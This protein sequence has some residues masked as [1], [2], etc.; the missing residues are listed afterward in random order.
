VSGPL[1][2]RGAVVTGGGRGI[3]AAIAAALAA[4]GAA[5]IVTARTASE[6][7][8]VAGDLT[9]RGFKAW[10]VACDVTDEEAVRALGDAARARLG[11]VDILVNN[12]G[13]SSSAPFARL[14]LAEWNRVLSVNA[15]GA[16]LAAREFV[17]AMVACGFGRVVSVASV[18]GLEG[19]KYIAHYCAAK[20]ALIG[21]TRALA[22][23]LA[24]TGVT[25]NAVCPGYADT[26]MTEATLATVQSKTGL[27]R[28]RALDAV[29]AAAG[30][31]RLVTPAEVAEAVLALCGADAAARNGEAI[32]LN[33][34]KAAR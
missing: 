28:E 23:E 9:A 34:A 22:V 2:G 32:V 5:V 4:A 8:H 16:F 7:E 12:A 15:T 31:E 14:S 1:A 25:A 33:P 18:A 30:Q 10:A 17:P 20:H 3:G 21:L 13:T 26:P 19:A 24:G 27:T 6:I 29:L 11:A